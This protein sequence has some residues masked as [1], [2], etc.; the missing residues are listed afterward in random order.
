M[1]HAEMRLLMG[2]RLGRTSGKD[3]Q[4]RFRQGVSVG[5]ERR[6]APCV[7]YAAAGQT[8]SRHTFDATGLA[9]SGGRSR[10]YFYGASGSRTQMEGL[11]DRRQEASIS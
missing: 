4:M 8:G 11:S 1:R 10:D 3:S 9:R 2:V 5:D 7:V 6:G